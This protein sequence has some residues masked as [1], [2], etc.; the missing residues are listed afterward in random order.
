MHRVK[1]EINVTHFSTLRKFGPPERPHGSAGPAGLP[2]GFALPGV[3]G[4]VHE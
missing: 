3:A 4:F 2:G 1:Q